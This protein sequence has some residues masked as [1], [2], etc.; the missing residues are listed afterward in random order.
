MDPATGPFSVGREGSA[1][2][3]NFEPRNLPSAKA[4]KEKYGDAVSIVVGHLLYPEDTLAPKSKKY[5]LEGQVITKGMFVALAVEERN[6]TS[7]RDKQVTIRVKARPK[8]L[9]KLSFARLLILNGNGNVVAADYGFASLLL[10]PLF[11]ETS[12]G[13]KPLASQAILSTASCLP[14]HKQWSIPPGKYR[15][16]ADVA[17]DPYY[18]PHLFS[19]YFSV[20]VEPG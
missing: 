17:L 19:N 3:V 11:T 7:G 14:G 1:V 18:R 5:C 16:I 4:L 12:N 15:A 6:V 9:R 13:P 2:V 20:V 8:T 10:R